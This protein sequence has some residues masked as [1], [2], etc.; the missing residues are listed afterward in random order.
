MRARGQLE[1]PARVDYLGI[2]QPAAVRLKTAL[3][4]VE[5]LQVPVAVAE[6]LGRDVVERVRGIIS[7]FRHDVVIHPRRR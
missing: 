5:D 7:G 6:S 4:Q 2:L 3:V 1:D